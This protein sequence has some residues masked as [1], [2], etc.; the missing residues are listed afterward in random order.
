MRIIITAATTGEWMPAFLDIDNLYTTESARCKVSFHQSGVGI[1]A[2][3][4]NLTKVIYEEKPDLIIQTGI[5]GSFTHTLPLETVVVVAEE[6]LGDLGVEEEG[7]WKDI[8]DLKLEKS[9]YPPFEKKRLPNPWLRQY[10]LLQLPQ[11]TG[12]TVNQI[13]TTKE[14]I[15]QLQKKYQPQVESMEG[16]A[17]H[18]VCRNLN[19]P[20]LQVRAISNLVGI[21]DKTRWSI[22]PAIEQLNKTVL[23]LVEAV[24]ALQ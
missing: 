6:I 13:S 9:S 5:A 1:L 22:K 7:K 18:Y 24:Y 17:L 21:R 10:N 11:V 3:A 8:F 14:R 4:V 23:K 16:A 20:F 12:I 2:T 19:T 15:E